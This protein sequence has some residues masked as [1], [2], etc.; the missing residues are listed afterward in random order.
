MT[1]EQVIKEAREWKGRIVSLL[2]STEHK[3]HVLK[4]LKILE[5]LIEMAEGDRQGNKEQ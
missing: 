1:D 3:D 5:R 2:D 4:R